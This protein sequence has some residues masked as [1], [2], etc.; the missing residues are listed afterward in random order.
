MLIYGI[1]FETILFP[2]EAFCSFQ[3]TA[4]MS[5]ELQIVLVAESFCP[6]KIHILKS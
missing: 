2:S 5:V 4:L 1:R 3:E 6:S